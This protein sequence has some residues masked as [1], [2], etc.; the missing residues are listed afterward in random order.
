[1]KIL[2]VRPRPSDETIGLQHVM[3][4]EP[5]E[6]EILSALKR[7]GDDSFLADLII[8]NKPLEY[9]L[10]GIKPDVL[11]ITGYITH[12]SIMVEYC[13][14]AKAY[15]NSV[16]TIV[17]GVHCEVCPE[18]FDHPA[19]DFRVVRNPAIVFTALLNHIEG[20]EPLPPG[21]L[22]PGLKTEEIH[23]P[24]FNFRIPFPD[25]SITAGQRHRYF[26]IFHNK[27]ALIK[28]SF[29]CPYKCTFCFC[30]VITRD[31]YR[32]RPMEEVIQELKMIEE[33]NIYIVDDDFLCDR[34]RLDIFVTELR[35]HNINKRFLVYGRADFIAHNPDMISELRSVGLSTVIVGFESFSENELEQYH[36]KTALDDNKKAMAVLNANKIDCF[37]TIILSPEWDKSDFRNMVK[38]LKELGIKYVNLQPLTPL[39][40][41]GV[42]YPREKMI[43]ARNEYEKWD[44]AHVSVMPS[45]LTVAEYYRQ[46]LIAYHDILFRPAVLWEHFRRYSFPMMWKMLSGTNKVTK[47]YKKKIKEAENK[48]NFII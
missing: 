34:K 22:T 10:T 12:V 25:R 31:N 36:K 32:Q 18:D 1:M 28:T 41:T 8:E 2:F 11:C 30:R 43:I 23:L 20:N 38:S 5:L 29:G 17:G 4:V 37:A 9:F 35:K 3:I 39:P 48:I 40:E 44:L 46:I 45:K 24:D 19:V 6:L 27:V 13:R 7:P 26:Y 14:I 15:N 42:S 47:Q 21:V 16:A 33:K